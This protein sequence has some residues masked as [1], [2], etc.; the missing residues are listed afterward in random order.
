LTRPPRSRRFPLAMA[1]V[2]AE[3]AERV[4]RWCAE[5]GRQAGLAL[6]RRA[7]APLGWEDL[8]A[9]RALLADPPPARPLGPFALADIARGAPP[10]IAAE[11]ERSGRYPGGEEPAPDE[12]APGAREAAPPSRPPR[13]R[14]RG[15]DVVIRRARDRVPAAPASALELPRV[16]DLGRPEGRGVLE[17]LIR[18]HG[19][20]RAALARALAAGW[21]RDD[22]AAPG[23]DDLSALL[24]HHGLARSFARRERDEMLHA[25]RAAGGFR[26]AAAERLALD[27]KGLDAALAA[28]GAAADAERIREGRRAEL[29]SRATLAE[30]VLLLLAEEERLRDLG[31]LDEFEADLR[32]RLPEHLRAL[33][34]GSSPLAEAFARSLSVE[35]AAAGRLAV[36]FGLEL[37]PGPERPGGG[38]RPRKRARGAAPR[39]RG[40]PGRGRPSGRRRG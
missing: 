11:R 4:A 35:R 9:V 18:S 38:S 10:D 17:R 28:A 27:V 7:L 26:P 31:L 13:R 23:E 3:L 21:R 22:G 6:I 39:R 1:D 29:R 33:R 36:R 16:A 8:L 24:E 14:R 32:A 34:L 19:A 5:A 40:G 2:D 12:P 37:G 30:R 20:R 15:S 25:L